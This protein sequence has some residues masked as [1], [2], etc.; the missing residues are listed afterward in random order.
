[1]AKTYAKTL[2][3]MSDKAEIDFIAEFQYTCFSSMY[4]FQIFP[5]RGLR[6]ISFAPITIFCGGNGS[7][8]STLLNILAEKTGIRRRTAMG[9]S[10]LFDQ[11]VDA[12]SYEGVR[13]PAGSDF[14]TSDDVFAYLS[15]VRRATESIDVRRTELF[16]EIQERRA[17]E[18]NPFTSLADY[19]TWLENYEARKKSMTKSKFVRQRLRTEVELHSNGESAMNYFAERIGEEALYLLDE[20][21][22]SLSVPLQMKLR[23]FIADSARFFGCQFVIA[24]H[25]PILL[26]LEDALIYDLDSVPVETRA[27]TEIENVRR[28]FEFFEEHRD[29]FDG[30]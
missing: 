12:C 11:Y 23:D 3:L 21:E 26:S 24:T 5:N 10:T 14:I 17:A 28:Y 9:R 20:P 25:S 19:D 29:E 7:G 13:T 2:T 6:E 1:M 30:V 8:K 4:P 15:D 16:E 27:W 18:A 22:N